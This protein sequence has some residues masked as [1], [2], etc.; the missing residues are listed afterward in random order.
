MLAIQTAAGAGL[1]MLLA[2][3][4]I[5]R[6]RP[7]IVP[8]LVQVAGFSYPSGHSIAAAAMYLTIMILVTRHF[9][10]L[11]DRLVL[12]LLAL[13]VILLVGL[14]RVYLGVHYPSDVLS[15]L[16]LGAAWAFLLAG[17]ASLVEPRHKDAV[18][19]LPGDEDRE[20]SG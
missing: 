20:D 8:H 17:F 3:G 4:I 19:P 2:K 18:D 1:W 12:L 14:S 10:A 9:P 7:D 11:R 13:A 5:E 15:G 6:A 16:S